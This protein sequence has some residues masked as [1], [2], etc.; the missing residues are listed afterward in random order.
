MRIKS[1]LGLG[2]SDRDELL[3]RLARLEEIEAARDAA[4]RYARCVDEGDAGSL[5]LVFA[6][7]ARLISRSGERRGREAIVEYY[8]Q[9]LAEPL[10]RRHLL[11]NPR[12]H[13]EGPGV[14]T[15]TSDFAF[16][17]LHDASSTELRDGESPVVL[18]WGEYVDDVR[19]TDGVGEIVVKRM[20]RIGE[21]EVPWNRA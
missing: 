9:T 3:A 13:W 11:A 20:Q 1:R 8:R 2:D 18:G 12:A 5:A 14:V 21:G 15:V 19:V 17:Y 6:E 16:V 7:D 10:V 4:W